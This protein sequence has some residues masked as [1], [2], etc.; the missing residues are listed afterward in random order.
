MNKIIAEE[1][2][3]NSSPLL[4]ALKLIA[5]GGIGAAI[6]ALLGKLWLDRKLELER[7]SYGKE[8]ENLKAKLAQKHTI[9]KLQFEKEFSIYLQ[10]WEGLV[11]LK[12]AAVYLKPG[13]Q[14][15]SKDETTDQRE[16]RKRKAFWDSYGEVVRLV[17]LNKPFYTETVY[18]E[19]SSLLKV[20]WDTPGYYAMFGREQE[21][22][23]VVYEKMK[24]AVGQMTDAIDKI[25]VSI[26]NRIGSI[27]KA[28]II[29]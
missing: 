28:E 19:A 10:L 27:S 21:P 12:D 7:A 15:T 26:R 3:R 22:V 2:V 23:K 6:I 4:E 25:E 8:L 16:E 17:E 18:K 13:L 11:K 29:E 24:T 1:L 20:A 5:T 9:H 14:I